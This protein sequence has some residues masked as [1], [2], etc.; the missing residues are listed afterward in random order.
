MP[1]LK[2]SNLPPAVLDHLLL[3]LQEK[4]ISE[5]D[6]MT[7]LGWI[8]KNPTVPIEDRFRRFARFTICGKGALIKTFLTSEQ[9][10]IGTEVD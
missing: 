7:L 9:T 1:K 2:R 10:A 4:G 5:E 6:L 3:R 8:E